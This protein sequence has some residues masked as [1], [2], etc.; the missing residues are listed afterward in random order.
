MA[1]PLVEM[2]KR[3]ATETDLAEHCFLLTLG[4]GIF[5]SFFTHESGKADSPPRSCLSAPRWPLEALPGEAPPLAAHE[6]AAG[7]CEPKERRKPG[8]RASQLRRDELKPNIF[9]G[10][11]F[12]YV[13]A[14]ILLFGWYRTSNPASKSSVLSLY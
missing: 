10:G 9:A 11:L 13:Y 5:F 1:P 4:I 7:V 2:C 14:T 8:E 6:A 3:S 12:K